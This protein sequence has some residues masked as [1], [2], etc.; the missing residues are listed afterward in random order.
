MFKQS[1]CWCFGRTK[2]KK[3]EKKITKNQS[4]DFCKKQNENESTFLIINQY[5]L[6]LLH[7]NI[8]FRR[9]NLEN[10]RVHMVNF[11]TW[12]Q[13]CDDAY[14]LRKTHLAEKASQF[15]K[16]WTFRLQI[17]KMKERKRKTKFCPNKV[18]PKMK[19]IIMSFWSEF[20]LVYEAISLTEK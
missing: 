7:F 2:R 16:G 5:K 14:F 6:L 8:H 3:H 12:G 4:D 19:I 9:R 13:L 17:K 11:K 1:I 10:F 18:I 20:S 15:K